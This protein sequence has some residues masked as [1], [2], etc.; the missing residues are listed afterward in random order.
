VQ[1]YVSDHFFCLRCTGISHASVF[2]TLYHTG[3]YLKS[4]QIAQKNLE[5]GIDPNNLTVHS[6]PDESSRMAQ[7]PDESPTGAPAPTVAFDDA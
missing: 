5:E 2:L 3:G 7:A 4:T 6:S 1:V